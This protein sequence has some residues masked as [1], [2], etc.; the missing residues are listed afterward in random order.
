MVQTAPQ[1]SKLETGMCR[2]GWHEG[3]KPK[4]WKGT[5]VQVCQMWMVCPCECHT[6]ITAMY[7][8]A[9]MPREVIT[10]PEY[11]R[12][13]RTWYMPVP[14]VDYAIDSSSSLVAPIT[15]EAAEES[16]PAIPATRAR[17][18]APTPTGRAAKGELE[19]YVLEVVTEWLIEHDELCTPRFVS[20]EI[21]RVQHIDPPSVGAIGAVFDRW[22][23]YGYAVISRKPVQFVD[24]TPEG[25]AKGLDAIKVA[26]KRRYK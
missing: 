22:A 13:E 2:A 23:T 12:P 16:T 26:Y 4:D 20:D 21:A 19:T 14:G 24:L 6:K 10:N 3:T 17:S 11:I 15:P 8:M 18:Y 9:E 5:P 1:K 7:E 25:R